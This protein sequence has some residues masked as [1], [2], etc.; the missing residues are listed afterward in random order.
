MT[1]HKMTE[2]HFTI[3]LLV[4]DGTRSFGP[5]EDGQKHYAACLDLLGHKFGE[6]MLDGVNSKSITGLTKA[7]EAA[8]AAYLATEEH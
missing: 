3:L 4:Q 8:L 5:V 2:E 1:R 6:Q 7:G